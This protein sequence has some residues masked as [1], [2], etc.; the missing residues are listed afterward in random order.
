V[1]GA[2]ALL[3]ADKRPAEALRRDVTSPGG[4]TEAAVNVLNGSN[5]LREL[6]GRAVAAATERGKA[7]GKS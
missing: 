6:M 2:G 3:E 7:L 5:G 4:T 1:S